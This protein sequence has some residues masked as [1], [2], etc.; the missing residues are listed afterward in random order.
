MNKK[1]SLE[2]SIQAIVIVVIAFVVLG[3]GL[4]FVRNQ[5]ANFGGIADQVQEQIK[6][7]ITDDLAR[8]DKKLSFPVSEITLNKKQSEVTGLGVKNVNVGTLKYRIEITSKG[9]ADIFGTDISDNFLYSEDV[10]ELSPTDTRIVPVRIT[11][12]IIPGTGQFKVSIY[13]VT[14]SAAETLYDSKTFF[15]TVTG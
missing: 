1:G 14:D 2:L 8:G 3:L 6:Q 10:E 4:G 9:G 5:F 11:S 15:I 7:Q 13:D 12:G